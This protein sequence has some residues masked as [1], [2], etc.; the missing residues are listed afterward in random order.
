[1]L[2]TRGEGAITRVHNVIQTG[3]FYFGQQG[4]LFEQHFHRA[5]HQTRWTSLLVV[6]AHP[7]GQAE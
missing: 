7:V 5:Q 1:M 3:P 6:G 2:S 4:V